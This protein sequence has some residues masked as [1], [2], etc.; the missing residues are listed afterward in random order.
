MSKKKNS[1]L[2][3]LLC[4]A[5]TT[6]M[7][8][9]PT[10]TNAETPTVNVQGSQIIGVGTHGIW[11]TPYGLP[12]ANYV[13]STSLYLGEEIDFDQ[14]ID[15]NGV[16]WYK[17]SLDGKNLGWV[18]SR[19]F[20]K[21]SNIEKVNED[22]YM[23]YMKVDAHGVWSAP[24]GIDGANYIAPTDKYAYKNV[25]IIEKAVNGKTT[26]V[27]ISIDGQVVGW[28]DKQVIDNGNVKP[29]NLNV[30][31]G[32][33]VG[34][35]IWSAPWGT[36]Y[37][38]YGGSTNQYAYQTVHVS[39][40]LKVGST[41]WYYISK[42][43]KN[44]GWVDGVKSL[45]TLD[46]VKDEN[47][48]MSVGTDKSSDGVWSA[49]Y[50]EP[51][52][53]WIDSAS[54]YNFQRVQVIQ[55]GVK[56]GTTWYK[57]KQGNTVLGWV[58][59]RVKSNI[60]TQEENKTAYIDVVKSS[61]GVWSQPYGVHGAYWIN[62]LS[63]YSF[64]E[65]KVVSSAVVNGTKW[66]DIFVDGQRLG[67]VDSKTL[68]TNFYTRY[69]DKTVMLGDVNGNGIWSVPYGLED[70][71]WVNGANAYSNKPIH[72][73]RRL[74]MGNTTWYNFEVDGREQGWVDAKA[75]FNATNIRTLNETYHVVGQSG[76]GVLS[77][78]WGM[79]GGSY[80]QPANNLLGKNLTMKLTM[81]YN[82]TTWYGFD[83]NGQF[84]WIDSKAVAR[85]A[86][87]QDGLS[88]IVA[89]SPTAQRTNQIVTVVASGTS[90]RVS[91][92]EK[93]DGL[94]NEKLSTNGFVG[95]QGVGQA[96]ESTSRTPKGSYSLGFSFGTSNPGTNLPFRQI[97]PNSYWISNVN[98]DQY[99]TWQERN[100]SSRSDE[101]LID[102]PAQYKYGI[103]INYNT[104]NIQKGAGS[105]FFLHVSNGKPTA[106][107][108]AIPENQMYE[109]MKRI[110]QG[111][112]IINV[113]NEQEI[114]NY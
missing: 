43:N 46:Q 10:I 7:L 64:K 60:E 53:Y 52:A 12:G 102:Y 72:V 23:G 97:T 92:F 106:G 69:E 55:S 86:V 2:G 63:N 29:A 65:A 73:T 78:P 101:H 113:N 25:K 89:S 31:I 3:T 38:E 66:Y 104:E 27:K 17:I 68:T 77:R 1:K 109:L 111:A 54:K 39:K 36:N 42:D 33:T 100:S 81:D 84:S 19:A 82:G 112:C 14:K 110:K 40:T 91:L 45:S 61:D 75:V 26:W 13:G 49:P 76:H 79:Q 35:D 80:I 4:V 28:V 18:D 34:N 16:T 24:Y 67:W 5:G 99:N 11:S 48:Y 98:D 6:L 8:A 9:S 59:S 47:F 50:G 56:N 62:S 44:I 70:A 88:G 51:G 103:V 105:G 22:V 114:K 74:V 21:L 32:N 71:R 30:V 94:W 37:A 41:N 15:L 85:G 93:E 83:Y 107:C 58:D 95:S 90:A 57:I 96:S 20:S 108:V 87:Q